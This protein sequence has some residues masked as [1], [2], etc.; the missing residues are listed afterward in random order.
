MRCKGHIRQRVIATRTRPNGSRSWPVGWFEPLINAQS[1]IDLLRYVRA[2]TAKPHRSRRTREMDGN[3]PSHLVFAT[4]FSAR[5]DRAQDR[6][7]QMA[8]RWNA[9]LTAVH[10]IDE[11]QIPGALLPRPSAPMATLR[12]AARLRDEF[13][14]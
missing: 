13:A 12:N 2:R 7:I 5:C 14:A 3:T 4:D 9:S 6:S 1:E 10:A 8:L 11:P